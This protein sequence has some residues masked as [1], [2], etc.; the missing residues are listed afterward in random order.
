MQVWRNPSLWKLQGHTFV[1]F[2][3]DI[4]HTLDVLLGCMHT[5][6]MGCALQWRFWLQ[7]VIGKLPF[8][9][10]LEPF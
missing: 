5:L 7:K 10:F 6:Q 3:K 8:K 1:F 4:I 9:S 2:K